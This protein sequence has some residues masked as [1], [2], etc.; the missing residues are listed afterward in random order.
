[1]NTVP[2]AVD[3][4]L[5]TVV[6]ALYVDGLALWSVELLGTVTDTRVLR[7][8]AAAVAG[9][10]LVPVTAGEG[11]TNQQSSAIRRNCKTFCRRG[12]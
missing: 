1:M 4:V 5:P 12:K 10:V 3:K 8:L 7:V 9:F 2:H 6:L 11:Y